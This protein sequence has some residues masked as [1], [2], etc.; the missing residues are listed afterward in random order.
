VFTLPTTLQ[1]NKDDQG[2]VQLSQSKTAP[3][4]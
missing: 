1:A 4:P 2:S 3:I